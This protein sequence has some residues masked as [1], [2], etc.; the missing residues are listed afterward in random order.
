[1]GTMEPLKEKGRKKLEVVK[2]EV[3][4]LKVI[5]KMNR[6]EVEKERKNKE[7]GYVKAKGEGKRPEKG[8]V[9]RKPERKKKSMNRRKTEA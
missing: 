6:T 1:M 9:N 5:R 8:K 2:I 7:N 3:R 4:E